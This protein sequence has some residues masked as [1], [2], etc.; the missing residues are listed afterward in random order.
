MT[1]NS[2]FSASKKDTG[3]Q[4]SS[5]QTYKRPA[6]QDFTY[7][8][9]G[10]SNRGLTP[11]EIKEEREERDR[12]LHQQSKEDANKWNSMTPEEQADHELWH[13]FP[14]ETRKLL[15]EMAENLKDDKKRRDEV[16]EALR[17]FQEDH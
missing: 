6:S 16:L 3:K 17:K 11:S 15:R 1:D 14:G 5:D 8:P 10:P 9:P 13:D 4:T 7:N 2:R 12:I